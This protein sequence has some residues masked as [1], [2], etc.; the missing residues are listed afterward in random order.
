MSI[1]LGPV[2]GHLNEETR[3]AIRIYQQG[4]GM[5]VDGKVTRE[6]WDLLNNAQRVRAL[7]LRLEK[8]R[9]SGRD[10]ARKALL[11]HP[12]SRDLVDQPNKERADPTRS[13][14]ACFNSPTV[15]YLLAEASESVKAVAR[16]ELRDWA[17]GELLVAEARAGLTEDAMQTVR[18]I[19]DPRLIMV[20][21]RDIAEAEA[22][23]GRAAEALAAADIIPDRN[24][25]A[26]ALAAI[27]EIQIRRKGSRNAR[28]TAARLI[29]LID[30]LEPGLPR[31]QL[32]C[33]VAVI[34]AE[35]GDAADAA[36]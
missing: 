33:R 24:K 26:D 8:A 6:L 11:S 32:K 12:A 10:A 16:P 21:L 29:G 20:A 22:A 2:D 17:L 31:V 5:K 23:S 18:R 30:G 9:R 28:A 27:A 35:I 15:R 34:V 1:Y 13:R 19:R 36:K 25:Q 14:D 3:T 7:L 4:V